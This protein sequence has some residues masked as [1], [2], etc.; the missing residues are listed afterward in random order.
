[1]KFIEWLIFTIGFIILMIVSCYIFNGNDVKRYNY[2]IWIISG[3]VEGSFVTWYII[4]SSDK[5]E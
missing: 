2:I 1:M 3:W 5:K 4:K